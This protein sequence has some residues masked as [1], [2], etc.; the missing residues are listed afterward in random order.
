MGETLIDARH[1]GMFP[2]VHD[3]FGHYRLIQGPLVSSPPNETCKLDKSDVLRLAIREIQAN[4]V[5]FFF[6]SYIYYANAPRRFEGKLPEMRAST[7]ILSVSSKT[8]VIT[9]ALCD[10][11]A[12]L[13]SKMPAVLPVQWHMPV[14]R[15]HIDLDGQRAASNDHHSTARSRSDDRRQQLI[16]HREL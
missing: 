10:R 9:A 3:Q 6:F 13:T 7:C 16:Y 5:I 15:S 11:C 8:P 14:S 4:T 12:C 1:I 2:Q